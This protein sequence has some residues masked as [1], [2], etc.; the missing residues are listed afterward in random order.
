MDWDVYGRHAGPSKITFP[1]SFQT[2]P[3]PERRQSEA[4]SVYAS[5][6]LRTKS[7]SSRRDNFTEVNAKLCLSTPTR[8]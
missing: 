2:E 4:A 1:V 3:Q 6:P 8:Q 7:F 5:N